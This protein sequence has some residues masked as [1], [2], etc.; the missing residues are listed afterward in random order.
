MVCAEDGPIHRDCA[1]EGTVLMETT[2]ED[3]LSWALAKIQDLEESLENAQD[4]IDR[5]V[6]GNVTRWDT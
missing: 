3:Q 6:E 2:I 1:T 4:I 5:L